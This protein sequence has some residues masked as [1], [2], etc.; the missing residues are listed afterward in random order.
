MDKHLLAE[1]P[2]RSQ[3]GGLCIIRTVDPISI[4]E[5]IE[6]HVKS[7]KTYHKHFNHNGEFYT[8]ECFHYFTTNEDGLLDKNVY[9]YMDDAWRWFKAYMQWEDDNI[10]R[11][12]YAINN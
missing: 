11:D 8:I 1:N 4:W 5:V 9:K 7:K 2:M 10:D 6:G 3:E 12:E